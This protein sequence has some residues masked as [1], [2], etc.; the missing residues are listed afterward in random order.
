MTRQ[1]PISS[2]RMMLSFC[3][4]I[5]LLVFACASVHQVGGTRAY[6]GQVAAERAKR[7]AM[8]FLETSLLP[9][10]AARDK[11][12]IRI[13]TVLDEKA[14]P[15]FYAVSLN[16]SGFII[17]PADDR[18]EPVLAFSSDDISD[19]SPES[20]LYILICRDLKGRM[21]RI[22]EHFDLT[23]NDPAPESTDVKSKW[24][25][26]EN[27][28]AVHSGQLSSLNVEIISDIYVPPLIATRWDQ[29]SVCG[30]YCYNYYIPNHYYAGCVATVMAQLM[31]FHQHPVLGIG[32]NTFAIT[33][34]GTPQQASTLGGDGSGGPYYWPDM[35]YSPDCSLT[36]AQRQA[37]GALC[38]DAG[39][40]VNMDYTGSVSVANTPMSKDALLETF[41]YSN[42]IK[43]TAAG[44]SLLPGFNEMVNPNLDAGFPVILGIYGVQDIGH[45]VLADG[46]GYNQGTLYHHLNMGWSGAYDLW[47]NLPDID[48]NPAYT[49]VNHCVYNIF[50]TGAGEIISG[51]VTDL[52]GA[53]VANAAIEAET[54]DGTTYAASTNDRGIYDFACVP[55][56]TTFTL[57]TDKEGLYFLDQIVATGQSSDYQ[58]S[59]GN[60]WAANFVAQVPSPPIA[61]D[62]NVAAQ[63]FIPQAII[64]HAI[65]E[66]HPDTPGELNYIITSLPAYGT[67]SEPQ[68]GVIES[69]DLPYTLRGYGRQVNYYCYTVDANE[70]DIFYFK[71][72][73]GGT[74]PEGGDSNA[75]RVAIDI[76]PAEVYSFDFEDGL[77]TGWTIVD[78]FSDGHT[79]ELHTETDPSGESISI[80]M[81]DGQFAGSLDE[82]LISNYL[83]CSQFD[84]L[85]ISF[86]NMFAGFFTEVAEV[87]IRV[88]EG[89]WQ[90]IA[91]F[92]GAFAP[93]VVELDVSTIADE[94]ADVQFRWHYT[95]P[96]FGFGWMLEHIQ[97]FAFDKALKVALGDFEPDGD[98][99]L[100]DFRQLALS[101][102][103]SVG[104]PN[105]NPACD[106]SDPDDGRIDVLDLV[107]FSENWLNTGK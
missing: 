68:A 36:Q 62:V 24:A 49:T 78:G 33:V 18:I 52:A 31:V 22:R 104:E 51:R 26:L 15:L 54:A 1:N 2:S 73:D 105:F 5:G 92:Q 32:E 89:P 90:N 3:A 16:P 67:L 98:V 64:L 17:L 84:G 85:S 57:R 82:Q 106:I 12:D 29:S 87:D 23:S 80:M 30:D 70:P 6:A 10:Q 100:N 61:Q 102:K 83:D 66:G 37:I 19:L 34:D 53:P 86:T 21:S 72:N 42:A 8:G 76:E 45:A 46:Y 94:Q 96:A 25:Y 71:A 27:S 44:S 101:W 50:P 39:L 41:G 58:S 65:D 13:R 74:A 48:S 88:N 69:D 9:S 11:Q 103:T 43:T 63:P 4:R 55:S 95:K 99:D 38:Y 7:A 75:A 47:Y 40:S 79:W 56:N 97:L 93:E 60:V 28:G 107:I 77:P 91:R 81:V 35:V 14:H 20:P 59:C